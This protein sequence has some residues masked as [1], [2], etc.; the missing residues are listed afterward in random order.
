MVLPY[1]NINVVYLT[2]FYFAGL[3]LEHLIVIPIVFR[4]IIQFEK[5]YLYGRQRPQIKC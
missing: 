4:I 1:Q 3:V 2:S 5:L